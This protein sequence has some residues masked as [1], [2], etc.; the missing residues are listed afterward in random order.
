MKKML[1]WAL[2]V[3]MTMT[4]Q[5]PWVSAEG[6]GVVP[7]DPLFSKQTYHQ[8]TKVDKAWKSVKVNS[9][10]VIAVLDTGVDLGH[11]DL[12]ANLVEGVNLV[13]PGKPPTDDNGHGTAA[14]G[15]LAGVGNNS[16]GIAGVLWKAKIMPIKV[17]D[18]NG[19]GD[20]ARVAKGIRTAVDKGAN[21]ILMSLGDPIYSTALEQAAQYA[22]QN[23]VLLI[24][25]TGNDESRV[26]YP[27][28]FPTVLSVGAV[29][30]NLRV[31]NYSNNG[32]EVDVVAPGSKIHSTS[33]GGVYSTRSGTSMAAPQV[34]GIA[35]L[36]L[37]Q[38][39]KL[40]P[41]QVRTLL[42]G[43]AQDLGEKGWDLNTGY[44]L[45]NAEKA[46]EQAS[47]P[48]KDIH[49]PNDTPAGAAPLPVITRTQG[50]VSGTD[51]VDW[52]R[53]DVPY[54][55]EVNLKVFP[56]SGNAGELSMELYDASQNRLLSA[57]PS[58]QFRT[59]LPRGEVLLKV[60]KKG[61]GT[62][63]YTLTSDFSIAADAYESNNSKATSTVLPVKK[64]ATVVGNFH[65]PKDVDWYQMTYPWE[66]KLELQVKT[67][68]LRMD[69]VLTVEQEGKWSKVVDNGSVANEQREQWSSAINPGRYFFQLRDYYGNAVDGQYTFSIHY[70]PKPSEAFDDITMHWSRHDIEFLY[71][72]GLIGGFPDGGYHPNEAITRGS[73]AVLIRRVL[74]LPEASRPFTFSDMGRGHWAY[75]AVA[76]LVEEGILAPSFT[77]RPDAPVSRAELVT[78][79]YR[80][81]F[82]TSVP[83]VQQKL[84]FSDISAG[85]WAYPYIYKMWSTGYVAGRTKDRFEPSQSTTRAEFAVLLK[86]IWFDK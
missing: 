67:D 64:Q 50:Q 46:V 76:S 3:T 24:A 35:A 28:A 12:K 52:Y 37:K 21:I 55:G 4:L 17:L 45:V 61:K 8:L 13:N 74:N 38:N 86:R 40:S 30:G 80:A 19:N 48:L 20:A 73:A 34:A 77:M 47:Q 71:G 62:S 22:E 78:M 16:T 32:P 33:S 63:D 56:V 15:I 6:E 59:V 58:N 41:Q 54:K 75:A 42:K 68:T 36:V 82:G 81:K 11:P 84:P 29:D 27:A 69:P 1:G 10:I 14:A 5:P 44:G 43:T 7:K 60:S 25:A 65:Q 72:K 70:N 2:A 51:P 49:E 57:N 53:I 39:P 23:N 18:A 66:G 9:N 79:L 26:T 31:L 85:N 83:K